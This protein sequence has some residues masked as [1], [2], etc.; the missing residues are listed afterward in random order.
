MVLKQIVKWGLIAFCLVQ[1]VLIFLPKEYDVQDF[2]ARSGT[3]YWNLNTGST[4]G[5]TK[6]K[7]HPD[8]KKSPVIYLH[9]GPGGLIKDKTINA[10]KPLS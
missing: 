4:I 9:G 8:I 1:L 5:Y 3:K 6:I 10:L 7:G 2:K